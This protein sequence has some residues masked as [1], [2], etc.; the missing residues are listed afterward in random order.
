M[1]RWI[2]SEQM[3][4]NLIMIKR[5]PC[6]P[7]CS[8]ACDFRQPHTDCDFRHELFEPVGPRRCDKARQPRPRLEPPTLA[9][10]MYPYVDHWNFAR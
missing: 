3:P 7:C 5:H 6:H 2:T 9:D 8:Q 10:S 4:P 1:R